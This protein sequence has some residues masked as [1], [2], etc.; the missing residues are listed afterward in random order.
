MPIY[1]Y[2]CDACHEVF[3]VRQK[4]SDPPPT[5]HSCGSTQVHRILSAT[6][7]VLKGTGWYAT[8]YGNRRADTHGAADKAAAEPGKKAEGSSGSGDAAAPGGTPA[9][10]K[11][12]GEAKPGAATAPAAK[13][14]PHKPAS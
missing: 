6:S 1:E 7:F 8:D 12:A 14:G 13:A 4:L 11:A 10:A 5:S 9:P 3:E 2:E